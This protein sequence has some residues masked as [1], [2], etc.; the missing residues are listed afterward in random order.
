MPVS[1]LSAT[2]CDDAFMHG[3]DT[4]DV[5]CADQ[6]EG[7]GREALDWIRAHPLAAAKL[8]CARVALWWFG[9]SHDSPLALLFT[10]LTV[11][12]VLGVMRS[13]ARI[14]GPQRA[15][16]LIPLI[17]HPLIYYVVAY[18]PAYRG[19]MNWLYLLLAGAAI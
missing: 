8:V 19:P 17:A 3:F 11:L 16:L 5:H 10:A 18:M 6:H 2:R 4:A 9:P 7:A 14:S 12:A 13:W 15:A 1:E